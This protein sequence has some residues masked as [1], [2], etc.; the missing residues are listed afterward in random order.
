MV[1]FYPVVIALCVASVASAQCPYADPVRLA[2][3]TPE[4]NM[5][6]SRDH[7]KEYE[8]DDSEGFLTSDVGGPMSDQESLKA[9]ERGSTLL[10]DFIFRQKMTHFDHERV[11]FHNHLGCGHEA[12]VRQVPE[13]AVHARGTGAYGTFTSYDD[14][15]NL[16]AASFLGAKDKKTPMFVRFS[17]VVGSRGSPD[18]ARDVRG[19][20]TRL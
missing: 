6:G 14:F 10:E 15:S 9:G 11:S 19:F 17:T 16:T 20:A 13:R 4:S 3:R 18:T 8:F 1:H 5:G 2:A 7:M 12:D